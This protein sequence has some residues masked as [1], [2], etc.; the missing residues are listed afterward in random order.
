MGEGGWINI[1][2]FVGH[3]W[4]TEKIVIF[5]MKVNIIKHLEHY[6]HAFLLSVALDN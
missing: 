1:S 4:P 6:F 5:L 3:L 2:I